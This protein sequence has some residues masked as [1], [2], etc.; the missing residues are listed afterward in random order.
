MRR[1]SSTARWVV[2][3][4][5]RCEL[6]CDHPP[7]DRL[8]A[9][10]LSEPWR[11][12]DHNAK[13]STADIPAVAA[14][15]GSGELIAAQLPQVLVMHDASDGSEIWSCA[16][17]SSCGNQRLGRIEDGHNDSMGMCGT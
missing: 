1:A 14:D 5:A 12:H 6:G 17:E 13:P 3:A 16:R 11:G 7:W 10:Q 9:S 4:L 8:A 2:A 15:V